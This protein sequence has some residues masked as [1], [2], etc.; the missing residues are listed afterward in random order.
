MSFKVGDVLIGLPRP[1]NPYKIT[2]PGVIV[3][4][5]GPGTMYYSIKVQLLNQ[6]LHTIFYVS[7]EAF[8][9]YEGP[10]LISLTPKRGL[11]LLLYQTEQLEKSL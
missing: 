2:G 10:P 3:E 4:V 8:C 6:S 9:L 7:P 1:L 11:A 5:I